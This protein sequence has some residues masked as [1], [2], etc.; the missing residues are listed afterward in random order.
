MRTYIDEYGNLRRLLFP[1]REGQGARPGSG[2]IVSKAP[3]EAVAK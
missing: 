1:A 2:G 3:P